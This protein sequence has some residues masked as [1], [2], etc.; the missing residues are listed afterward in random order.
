M[1]AWLLYL[2]LI[3]HQVRLGHIGWIPQPGL[4]DLIETF[5]DAFTAGPF[6]HNTGWSKGLIFV[7]YGWFVLIIV[8]GSVRPFRPAPGGPPR[9]P[10]RSF[11]LVSWLFPVVAPFL[12]SLSGRSIFL[13]DRY[14]IYALP[15]LL[16]SMLYVF[17]QI[18][19]GFLRRISLALP[20]AV[21]IPLAMVHNVDYWQHYQDFDWK[22]AASLVEREWR[23]G[24]AAVFVPGWMHLTYQT[25]GGRMEPAVTADYVRGLESLGPVRVWEFVWLGTPDPEEKALSKRLHSRPGAKVRVDF[26]HIQLWEIPMAE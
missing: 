25:N 8:L 5:T 26:P 1:A 20:A 15:A 13:K 16:L 14:T 18:R 19:P 9:V 3:I 17:D 23:A 24:D 6:H 21:L 7:Y 11:L 10:W 12:I 4:R 22:G 2:P